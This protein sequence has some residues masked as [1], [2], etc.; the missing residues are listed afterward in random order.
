MGRPDNRMATAAWSSSLTSLDLPHNPR[1][2][3]PNGCCE[4]DVMREDHRAQNIVV[5]VHGVDTVE[6]RNVLAEWRCRRSE[7]S[8]GSNARYR[9]DL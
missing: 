9:W 4:A 3:G 2:C 5:S 8:R 6:N 7:S 1:M